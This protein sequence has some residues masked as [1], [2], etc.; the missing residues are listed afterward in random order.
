MAVTMV[1]GQTPADCRPSLFQPGRIIPPWPKA[2]F[3]FANEIHRSDNCIYLQAL[4]S[5]WGGFFLG[6]TNLVKSSRANCFLATI[7]QTSA[8]RAGAN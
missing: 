1:I 8:T 5:K 3:G 7:Q 4:V 2:V 6:D